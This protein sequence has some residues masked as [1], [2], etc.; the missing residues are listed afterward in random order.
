MKTTKL[1][2][3]PLLFAA[4]ATMPKSAMSQVTIGADEPPQSFSVLELISNS[5]GLRLPQLTTLQRK[6]LSDTHGTEEAIKGLTIY[7]TIKN[8]VEY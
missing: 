8:C 1:L 2:L 6:A 3:F 4:M 7:N 5:K